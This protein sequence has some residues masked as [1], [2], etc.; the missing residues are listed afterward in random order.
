[1][2]KNHLSGLA[3]TQVNSTIRMFVMKD[4]TWGPGAFIN[5]RISEEDGAITS[6]ESCPS[7]PGKNLKIQRSKK[8][9]LDYVDERG[10]IVSDIIEGRFAI[11]V[12]HE[13]DHLN[14]ILIIDH[15]L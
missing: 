15:H 1:M 10:V 12:Q 6:Y 9:R 3:S 7:L 5:P 4:K 2:K 8:I 13:L 11:T 14:G